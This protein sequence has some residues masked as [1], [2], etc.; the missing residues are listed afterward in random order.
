V[1]TA[2]GLALSM[3]SVAWACT[4]Q[5][6]VV[7]PLS[8]P[9]GS[10]VTVKGGAAPA[11]AQVHIL[12]NG[13]DGQRLATA[14]TNGAGDFSTAVTVPQVAPGVYFMVIASDDASEGVARMAFEVTPGAGSQRVLASAPD[15]VTSS[16]SQS[17][18]SGV[19]VGA[20]LLAVGVVALFSGFTFAAVRR[21]RASA[22]STNA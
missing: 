10:E 9:S 3:A 13:L 19:A 2:V 18:D 8:G 17:S 6:N 1:L 20:A 14:P 5:V 4:A 16:G 21:S 12:W 11:N 7:G 22:T 15:A